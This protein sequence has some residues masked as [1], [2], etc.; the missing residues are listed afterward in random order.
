MSYSQFSEKRESPQM[1][2][3]LNIDT[4][5]GVSIQDNLSQNQT[6]ILNNADYKRL[7]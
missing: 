7:K 1:N 6:L 5:E 3:K 2:S 4:E